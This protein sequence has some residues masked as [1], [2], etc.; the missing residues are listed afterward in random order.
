VYLDG[1]LIGQTPKP[2]LSIKPGRHRVKLVNEPMELSKSFVVYI[3]PGQ[4]VTR[5]ENL[6]L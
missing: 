5:S 1:T 4:V 6:A 3:R 2:S